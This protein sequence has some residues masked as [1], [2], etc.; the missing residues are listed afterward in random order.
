MPG[1]TRLPRP[2]PAGPP[3]PGDLH[4][5][6]PLH[7]DARIAT[8]SSTGCPT[9]PA[10]SSPSAPPTPSSSRPSSAGSWPSSSSTARRHPPARSSGSAIDRPI[11]LEDEP[12]DEL[13]GL[14]SDDA[15]RRD[16]DAPAQAAAPPRGRHRRRRRPGQPVGEPQRAPARRRRLEAWGLTVKLGDHVNDRHGYMAGRDEDRAAD[17]HAAPRRPGGPGDRLP[18]GRLRHAAPD[19]APRRGGLRRQPE[20]DL[21]LQRPHDAPSRPAALGQRDQLLLERGVRGRRAGGHGLLEGAACSGRCS[22]TSRTARSAR[23]RTTPTSG[24]SSAGGRRAA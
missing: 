20:G 16:D 7:A 22:A 1:S 18:P 19:P 2:P 14:R 24:R 4:E 5:D 15:T 11:L 10:S 21:R 6:L 17:L 3:R 9:R 8:S 23:T 12:G 13:P